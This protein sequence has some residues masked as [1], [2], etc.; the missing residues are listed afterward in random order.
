MTESLLEQDAI[1]GRLRRQIE[2]YHESA[3]LYAAVKLGLA[4]T[5]AAG[6][7]TA[8]QLA[9]AL[10]LSTPHLHRFLRGL[11]TIGICEERPDGAFALAPGGQ[12]LKSDSPSRLAEKVQIVVG[13]YWRP[14]AELVSTLQTG[15]PSF[16]EVFGKNVASWRRDNAPQG[17][18]FE[19]YLAKE[20]LAQADDIVAVLDCSGVETVAEIGG[21]YGGLLAAILQAYPQLEGVL[22]ERPHTIAPA[23]SFMQSQGL[24]DRVQLI[25]GDLLAAIPVQADLY[26]LKNV[27]QNWDDD[28][29]RPILANCRKA[30]RNGGKLV[31]IERLLPDHATDDP[32]AIMLDLH[33]MTITGGHTRS[34]AEFAALLS[35]TDLAVSKVTPTSS[36][37]WLIEAQR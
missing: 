17:K 10:G 15:T 35:A 32:A 23:K 6:P 4:D 20:T 37:L 7:L 33:M 36:G 5:L 30:M 2:A 25:G 1:E 14:W 13:Q 19:S 26:L 11:C 24:A 3:L 28:A 12:C 34:L 29:A 16:D 22:F 18:L 9:T 31:I 8:E 21:G 27:L